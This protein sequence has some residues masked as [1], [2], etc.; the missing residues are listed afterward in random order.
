MGTGKK[1][2]NRKPIAYALRSRIDKLDLVKLQS[3]CKA[4]DTV[5]RTK[6][7]PT[8]WEKIFTNPTSDRGLIS[9]IY[10]ELKKSNPREPNSPIKISGTE[11]KK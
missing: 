1:F 4:N 2:L 11:L 8:N 10:K 5:K 3:F 6:Q 9:N 7:Q